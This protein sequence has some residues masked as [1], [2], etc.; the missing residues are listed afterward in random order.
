MANVRQSIEI[1]HDILNRTMNDEMIADLKQFIAVTM[2]QEIA[3]LNDK[4]DKLSVKVDELQ[5]SV[6][7]ALD[8]TNDDVDE[9]LK[10]HDSRLTRLEHKTA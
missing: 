3:P 10:D 6:A 5:A 2:R 4:F 8:T 9:Q 7:E 1:N